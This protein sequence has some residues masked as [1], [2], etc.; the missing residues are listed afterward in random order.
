MM[1]TARRGLMALFG[2]ALMVTGGTLVA[3]AATTVAN[4]SSICPMSEGRGLRLHHHGEPQRDRIFAAGANKTPI[5]GYDDDFVVGVSITRT[6]VHSITLSGTGKDAMFGFDGDEICT[7]NFTGD[8]YCATNDNGGP[9]YTT[10]HDGSKEIAAGGKNPYEAEG[11]DNTF[12][13]IGNSGDS[14][15]INFITSLRAPRLDVPQPGVRAHLHRQGHRGHHPRSGRQ[16]AHRYGR[17]RRRPV[18]WQV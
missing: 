10:L 11:P 7:Y 2:V 12:S 15:T 14:G 9:S 6:G 8:S 3:T 4:A 18:Q 1:R 17:R 16:R 5:D 13:G